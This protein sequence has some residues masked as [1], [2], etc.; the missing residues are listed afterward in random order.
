MKVGEKEE[1]IKHILDRKLRPKGNKN[2]Q[3]K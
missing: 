2:I 3:D 1:E